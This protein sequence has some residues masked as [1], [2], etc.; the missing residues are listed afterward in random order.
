MN[1]VR[2]PRSLNNPVNR[3]GGVVKIT[4]KRVPVVRRASQDRAR[5]GSPSPHEGTAVELTFPRTSDGTQS[6][7]PPQAPVQT[8]PD[9][10]SH[11]VRRGQSRSRGSSS[12]RSRSRNDRRRSS[13]S[14]RSRSRRSRSRRSH[15]R[16]SSRDSRSRSRTL[17]RN[18]RRSRTPSR[19]SDRR[20]KRP[21]SR[22]LVPREVTYSSPVGRDDPAPQ[23]PD[24]SPIAPNPQPPRVVMVDQPSGEQPERASDAIR[25]QPS[26]SLRRREAETKLHQGFVQALGE[27]LSPVHF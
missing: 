9:R 15:S 13:R 7:A 21:R 19:D 6:Q 2:H 1:P 18:R 11:P 10:P 17:R 5:T 27:P 4:P 8:Q 20:S 26:D 3:D 14:P 22:S 23:I 25:S 12:G 24:V 16:R